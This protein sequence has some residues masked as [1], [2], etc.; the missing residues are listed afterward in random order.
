MNWLIKIVLDWIYG[1]VSA[2]ISGL[3]RTIARQKAIDEQKEQDTAALKKADPTDGDAIDK[4]IDDALD[5]L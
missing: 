5:H 4:G 2:F 1:K 3:Y